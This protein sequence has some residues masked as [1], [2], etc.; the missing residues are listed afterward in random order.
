MRGMDTTEKWEDEFD[1]LIPEPGHVRAG[2]I[3][4]QTKEVGTHVVLPKERKDEI[5][6]FISRTLLEAQREIVEKVVREIQSLKKYSGKHN[7]AHTWITN[8]YCHACQKQLTNQ[9]LEDEFGWNAAI[10]E[11]TSIARHSLDVTKDKQV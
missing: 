8:G 4:V 10:D 1:R 3:S 9:Q 6:S 5:K 11:V 7:A 2:W